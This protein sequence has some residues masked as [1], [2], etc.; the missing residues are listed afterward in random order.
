MKKE[1]LILGIF[2]LVL[3]IFLF[4]FVTAAPTIDNLV[5]NSTTNGTY[6]NLNAYVTTNATTSY[7]V[8]VAYNWY[9][10]G[11]LNRTT[12]IRDNL[13][14]YF[15]FNEDPHDYQGEAR[16]NSTTGTPTPIS[17]KVDGGYSFDGSSY[18][19]YGNRSSLFIGTNNITISF[20]AMASEEIAGSTIYGFFG[21]SFLGSTALQRGWEVY[22]RFNE[23]GISFRLGNGSATTTF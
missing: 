13:T 20:W 7:N 16:S 19:N 12:L 22:Y 3:F 21:N 14:S 11:I 9:L 6:H 8:T 23:K 15:S 10:N 17:G 5:L 2:I 18:F 4:I 1:V